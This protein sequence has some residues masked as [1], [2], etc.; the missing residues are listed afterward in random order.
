M[1]VTYKLQTEQNHSELHKSF[2]FRLLCAEK[3]GII[4][5][6]FIDTVM[7]VL[8]LD[9]CI[10][11]ICRE[12]RVGFPL[13]RLMIMYMG[14]LEYICAKQMKTNRRARYERFMSNTGVQETHAR[15]LS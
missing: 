1:I 15:G 10:A 14:D 11:T 4:L 3:R 12:D 9:I 7:G 5:L 13:V 8:L 2:N 6:P